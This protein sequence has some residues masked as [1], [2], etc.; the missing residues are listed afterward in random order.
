MKGKKLSKEARLNAK[1]LSL[2]K[3]WGKVYCPALERDIYFTNK[4][5]HHIQKEKWRTRGEKESRLKL[6][7]LAKHI[8]GVTTTIQGKRLQEYHGTPHLH[9]E[10]TALVDTIKVTVIVIED[11][12]QYDFL[13]VFRVV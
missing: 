13:S 3:K 8:L 7:P 11:K 5:W 1:Y 4:G 2:Y 9:F 10:F 12:G 6:L